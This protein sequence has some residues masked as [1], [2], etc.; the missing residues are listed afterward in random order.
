MSPI[1]FAPGTP[2]AELYEHYLKDH[3]NPEDVEYYICGPP[4]MLKACLDMLDSLG[5]EPSNIAFDREGLVR[6]AMRTV[7]GA[8][9]RYFYAYVPHAAN[10][11]WR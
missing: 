4:L 10:G 11:R 5:V 2:E 1:S 7:T 6:G 3:P 9:G 8:I